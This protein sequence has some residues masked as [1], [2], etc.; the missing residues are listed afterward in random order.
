MSVVVLG[1]TPGKPLVAT[2]PRVR[3]IGKTWSMRA[4]L[5]FAQLADV[6]VGTESAIVNAVSFEPML[7]LVLLSHSSQDNLTRDWPETIS[8]STKGLACH[9]CHRIHQTMDFC[10]QDGKT[11]AA[12]CQASVTAESVAHQVLD[13]LAWKAEQSQSEAV[14]A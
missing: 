13:Y 7:K 4:A 1:D 6:V 5:A 2:S 11:L 3:L 8:Y 12:A 9:P 14:A 10:T